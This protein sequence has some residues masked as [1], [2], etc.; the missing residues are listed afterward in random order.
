MSVYLNQLL[1][2]LKHNQAYAKP[3]PYNTQLGPLQEMQFR[4]W[5]NDNKVNFDPN[6]KV[7]DYDMRGFWL[8]QQNGQAPQT[9]INQYDHKLHFTDKFKTPY[10]RDFSNQSRYATPSA[11]HWEKNRYLVDSKGNIVFDQ[12][13][14]SEDSPWPQPTKLTQM[15]SAQYEANS[16]VNALM[17]PSPQGNSLWNLVSGGRK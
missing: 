8:A 3:G 1:E 13:T 12:G 6:A 9:A 10:D 17:A 7:T 14:Q 4:K 16:L 5:L 2:N 15:P 11:P